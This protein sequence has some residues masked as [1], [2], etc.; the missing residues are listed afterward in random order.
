MKAISLKRNVGWPIMKAQVRNDVLYVFVCL[1][2]PGQ[3]PSYF[4]ATGTEARR[5]VKQY[6]T[7]GIINFGS[8]NS[9][10]HLERWDKIETALS[11][12]SKRPRSG[13]A[14][15]QRRVQAAG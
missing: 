5:K 12:T 8:L 13:R 6:E 15:T 9:A 1:N 3:P 10:S 4:I 7:R 11:P 14:T 2:P